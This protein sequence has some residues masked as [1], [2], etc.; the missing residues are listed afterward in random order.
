MF[1]NISWSAYLLFVVLLLAAWYLFVGVRYYF[2]EL[3]ALASGK[4]SSFRRIVSTDE[5]S[6]TIERSKNNGTES[7]QPATNVASAEEMETLSAR[8]A[9]VI[10][11]AANRA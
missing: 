10:A 5:Q 1:T 6:A 2:G 9:E 11:K 3:Q 7:D 8:L 4:A